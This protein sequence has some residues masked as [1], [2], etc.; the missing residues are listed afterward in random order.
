[1]RAERE[2]RLA[3]AGPPSPAPNYVYAFFLLFHGRFAEADR[4]LARMVDIDPFSVQTKSNLA[5][6][7]GVEGRFREAREIFQKAAAENPK[8]LWAQLGI[9]SSY[10]AEGHPD[11][12]FP[13]ISQLKTVWPPATV[14]EAMAQAKAGRK[15]QALRLLRPFEEKSPDPGVPMCWIASVYGLLGDEPNTVK[16]LERSADQH[17]IQ[18]LFVAYD[19][20]YAPMRRSPGFRALL[21]R[22]GL[23][24]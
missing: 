17:E 11:L 12:A 16:W 24:Q 15:D 19:P 2:L 3:V 7:R 1:V 8:M 4:Y 20:T 10:I 23:D 22:I 13:I 21:K 9:A 6:A 18:V 5:L 14:F